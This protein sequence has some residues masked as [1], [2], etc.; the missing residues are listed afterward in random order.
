M[1]YKA[2]EDHDD[3]PE[4]VI[5]LPDYEI[6]IKLKKHPILKS[7]YTAS[8]GQK[9]VVAKMSVLQM[10]TAIENLPELEK[11]KIEKLKSLHLKTVKQIGRHQKL[12]FGV[13]SA[14][15]TAYGESLQ[16]LDKEKSRVL[17]LLGRMYTIGDIMRILNQEWKIPTTRKA[18]EKFKQNNIEEVN[19]RI[20]EYKS[21]F[22]TV[23]LSV[24]RSRLD[25]LSDLYNKSKVKYLDEEKRDDLRMLLQILEQIRKESEGER[26]TIDGKVDLTYEQNINIHLMQEVFKTLNLKE[27]ILG[28]VAS[29]MNINPVKL[30]HSL[31]NSYYKNFSNVLG[32]Y[33]ENNNGEELVYPSQLNYDFEKIRK[34]FEQQDEAALQAVVIDENNNVNSLQSGLTIKQMLA[35]RLSQKVRDFSSTIAVLDSSTEDTV[36]MY[37]EANMKKDDGRKMGAIKRQKEGTK[38]LPKRGPNKK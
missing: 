16:R 17:E 13:S 9:I 29:K 22:A 30:I 14:S 3:I 31:S 5:S 24:K 27:I 4:E 25:E 28:R 32:N 33:S 15:Y 36:E 2:I 19:R 34:N 21:S 35:M 18:L 10:R 1:D 37:A 26:L 6:L 12:A 38:T 11:Q 20:T 8:D 7:S 23:R